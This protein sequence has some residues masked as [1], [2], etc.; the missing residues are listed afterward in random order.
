[1][2]HIKL[3]I[4]YTEGVIP[5]TNCRCLAFETRSAT[6]NNTND[7]GTNDTAIITLMATT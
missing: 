4:Q 3:A 2:S 1:M 6:K 7:A 5:D